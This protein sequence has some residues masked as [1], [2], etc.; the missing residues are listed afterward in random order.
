MENAMELDEMKNLWAQSNRKLEASMRLNVVLLQQW[1]LSRLD[2]LL[3]RLKR[4]LIFELVTSVIAVAALAYFGYQR[5]RE[6]QFVIP[7]ALLY[8][9]ALVYLIAVARQLT[10]ITGVDYDEPVVAIQKKLEELRLARVRTTLW[11]LLF[12]PLM[13]LPILI[14]GMLVLFGVD[15]YEYANPAWLAGNALFGLAVIPLAISLAR[16]YGR[17]LEGTTAIRRL[18]DAIAGQ[19]LSEARASLDSI[20]R[21]EC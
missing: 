10:Q 9:Y 18:A 21:F 19:T 16:R 15:V 1:N 17:R 2:T 5:L 13:W 7:A 8:L 4:G 6:P 20:R 11:A 3:G 12:A 14:V